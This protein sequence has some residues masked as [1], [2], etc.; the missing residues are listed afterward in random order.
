LVRPKIRR[1]LWFVRLVLAAIALLLVAAGCDFTASDKTAA[2]VTKEPQRATGCEPTGLMTEATG[3]AGPPPPGIDWDD[4][5]YRGDSA[6]TVETF[7]EAEAKLSF[8]GLYPK[9]LKPCEIFV[10]RSGFLGMRFQHPTL[11]VFKIDEIPVDVPV[12]RLE[13]KYRALP[14]SCPKQPG[15]AP[16]F[17]AIH[18]ADGRD[19]VVV[20]SKGGT[21]LSN[22]AVWFGERRGNLEVVV[23]GPPDTFT[24]QDAITVANDLVAG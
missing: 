8:P 23:M 11:G 17:T 12:S 6:G 16:D 14:Q 4:P 18:L 21:R 15:C 1:T 5:W 22:H 2:P 10:G 19:A 13:R 9:T 20:L 24:G 7:A 3:G